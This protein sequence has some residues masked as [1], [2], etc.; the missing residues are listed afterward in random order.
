MAIK[1]NLLRPDDLLNLEVEGDNLRLDTS[2]PKAPVV[3]LDD[4][5]KDGYLIVTFP[6]Q[7]VIEEA[8]FES[9]PTNPPPDEASLPYNTNPPPVVPPPYPAQARIG[10]PTHLVF[11]IPAA[12]DPHIPYTTEGLLDWDGF[13]PNVSALADVPPEPTL[14]E[15]HNAPGITKPGRLD[16]SIELPYRLHLS[17]NHAVAWL[18]ARGLRTHAGVTEL[19]HTRLANHPDPR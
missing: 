18:H 9:S 2:D 11:R 12:L 3:V 10:G 17:P 19:W 8:V 7:A 4:K 15:R 16:T 13:T 14:A 5:Q 1:L 6:P